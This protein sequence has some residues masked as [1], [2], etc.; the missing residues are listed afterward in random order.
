MKE[1]TVEFVDLMMQEEYGRPL[2][3]H[4]KKF[5]RQVTKETYVVFPRQSGRRSVVDFMLMAGWYYEAM[6][7][8][9]GGRG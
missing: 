2:S 9:E 5:L 3:E 1:E 7:N 4:E 6:M 8:D